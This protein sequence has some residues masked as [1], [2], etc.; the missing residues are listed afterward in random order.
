MCI[1]I[2]VKTSQAEFE[3]KDKYTIDTS[4][5]FKYNSISKLKLK[6]IIWK[7]NPRYEK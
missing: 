5:K 6:N 7:V 4:S 2:N 1:N 3:V